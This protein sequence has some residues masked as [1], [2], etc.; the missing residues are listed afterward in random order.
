MS[1]PEPQ[2]ISQNWIVSETLRRHPGTSRVFLEKETFCVGCYM[3][4]FCTL[5]DVAQAFG[6][7]TET[8]V[9][10]I[11]QAAANEIQQRKKEQ[12]VFAALPQEKEVWDPGNDQAG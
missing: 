9:A 10:E 7:E 4:R 12:T 8:L 2:Q 11:D 3:A 1:M 6:L 5:G